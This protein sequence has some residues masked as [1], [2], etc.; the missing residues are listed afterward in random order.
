MRPSPLLT[1]LVVVA[2]CGD[3]GS[4]RLEGP[5]HTFTVDRYT[6]PNSNDEARAFGCDLNGDK[7][8]DN[9]LGMTFGFLASENN[10][11]PYIDDLIGSRVLSSRLEIQT[12][13]LRDDAVAGAR[14]IGHDGAPSVQVRG[15]L[16]DG[17]FMTTEAGAA[18]ARLP[19][20]V[21][22]DVSQVQ[23]NAVKVELRPDGRGGYDGKLCG[24]VRAD[25]AAEDAGRGLIQMVDNNP[26]DHP[27][28]IALFDKD[29]N[30]RITLEE[31]RANSFFTSVLSSDI[32]IERERHT[33]VG[34]LVHVSACP[35]GVC[36][37]PAAPTNTCHDRALDGDESDVDCGGASCLKCAAGHVCRGPQDC[38]SNACDNG[39]CREATCSDGA[40]DG[41]ESDVDCGWNC[42]PCAAGKMCERSGDCLSEM[43]SATTERCL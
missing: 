25:E 40:W 14:Y 36:P 15:E 26:A 41:F 12:E 24:A 1:L 42:G 18:V 11:T 39:L 22:A 3:S 27:Y 21:D 17:V 4:E 28:M 6:L 9:Q 29:M 38:A 16:D 31:T 7:R 20:F 13:D 32:T 33:S 5:V 43:C 8:V 35:D 2:G 19:V 34:V 37:E 23:L 30:G 10:L